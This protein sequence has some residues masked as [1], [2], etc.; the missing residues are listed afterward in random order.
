MSRLIL[1]LSRSY[2]SHLL[3]A[4]GAA[5][6]RARYLH[7]VQTDAEEALVRSKGGEVVLNLQ[8]A[9]REDLPHASDWQEPKD[10]R[11][12]T[13]FDWS[14]VYADRYLPNHAAEV[15]YKI[16]AVLDRRIRQLFETHRFDGVLGE[17][18]A[19]FVTHLLLYYCK[20]HGVQPLFWANTYFA[21]HFYFADHIHIARPVPRTSV[22]AEQ[23]AALRETVTRYAHGI[24]EDKTG[25]VYHHAFSRKAVRRLDYFEQRRGRQALVLRPGWVSRGIQMLRLGRIMALKAVFPKRSDFMSAGSVAEHKFYLRNLFTP[26]RYYDEPP[27]EYSAQNVLFPLQYEPEASLLY[28]APDIVDQPSFVEAMLRALPGDC[29][30]WVKEHPNQFG[31]LGGRRWRELRKRY[32]NL[33]FVFGRRNGRALIRCCGLVVTISSTAG[34]DGLLLGRRVLVAGNVFYDHF[35]GALKVRSYAEL[36]HALNDPASYQPAEDRLQTQIEQLCAFGEHA[37][38]GD[39]Q[40]SDILFEPS[41]IQA[42][43][44]AIHEALSGVRVSSREDA[45]SG[46]RA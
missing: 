1:C 30:L 15:R 25:P 29:V 2:L 42:L 22:T 12:V 27:E 33:R 10:F 16:A 6:Q 36:A 8:S 41:N 19:I 38:P 39:P 24:V 35:A 37:Y 43:L 31:A 18:V 26:Q 23:R 28:F 7:I 32:H 9:V 17:P 14:P 4:L 34:L 21:D 13:S 45:A 11:R 46:L 40:P 5:D 20:V 3:P 44:A